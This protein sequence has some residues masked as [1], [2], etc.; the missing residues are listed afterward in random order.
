M[1][2]N[3]HGTIGSMRKTEPSS[4]FFISC[5]QGLTQYLALHRCSLIFTEEKNAI[6]L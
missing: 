6:I 5:P 2:T 3:I 4:I 1:Y